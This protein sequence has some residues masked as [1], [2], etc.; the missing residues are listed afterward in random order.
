[1]ASARMSYAVLLV[2]AVSV[3]AFLAAP[4]GSP[5]R[6]TAWVVPC[7]LATCLLTARLVAGPPAVRGPLRVLLTGSLLYTAASV[8]WSVGPVSFGLPLPFPSPLDAAFITSYAVFAAFLLL[9]LRRGPH[10]TGVESRVAVIDALIPTASLSAVLWVAVVEPNLSSGIGAV[11]TAVAIVYPACGLV[12]FALAIRLAVAGRVV[13][14]VPGLLL[15]AW[16][17]CELAGLLGY[18]FQ[19]ANGTFSYDGLLMPLWT[20]SHAA[21]GALAVHPG[22]PALLSSRSEADAPR[23]ETPG[24]R[25]RQPVHFLAALVPLALAAWQQEHVVALLA[26]TAATFALVTYRASLVAGDLGVQRRLTEELGQAVRDVSAHRDRLARL[27]AVVESTDDA[28]ILCTPDGVI[29]GWNAGAERLY[30]YTEAEALGARVTMLRPPE[31]VGVVRSTIAQLGQG[32]AVRMER[33]DVRKDGSLVPTSVTV[34]NIYDDA[35]TITAGVAIARDMTE[36]IRA[37]EQARDAARLLEAQA[38]QLS[39]LAFHDPLTGLGNRALFRQELDE[40]IQEATGPRAPFALVVLDLDD[41]KVVNDSLGHAT[42]DALLVAAADRLRGVVGDQGT[43]ARLGGDEFAVVLP[44]TDEAA[45]VR[46][47]ELILAQCYREFHVLGHSLRTTASIGVAVGTPGADAADL[48]RNADLAMYAAKAA[49]KGKLSV[50]QHEMLAEAQQRLDLENH[51]R[52][53]VHREELHLEYQPIVDAATGE[54][55]SVEAL[56]RWQHPTWGRVSPATFIPV[57]ET[58]GTIVSLGTWVLR[59]ACRDARELASRAGRPV[60]VAVNVSVRQLHDPDFVSVV[61]SALDESGL[62]A[63]LLTLEVTESLLMDED[64]CSTGVLSRLHEMGVHLSIDDFGTGHSSLARLR[65]LPVRELKIDRAFVQEI[66]AEGESGPIVTAIVAMARALGLSVVA[67]GVETSVQLQ[68]LR[69]LGCDAVQGFLLARPVPLDDLRLGPA[70]A[71][72]AAPVTVEDHLIELIEKLRAQ[73]PS[74]ATM[75][76]PV[77]TL[78]REALQALVSAT[79]LDTMYLTRVD[80]TAGLQ[81]VLLTHAAGEDLVP[82]GLVVD[83][84]D[85]LCKRASDAG[86]AYTTDVPGCFPDS[87]AARELGLMTYVSVP[88]RR[89]DGELVGTLCG[90]SAV[91]RDLSP[92]LRTLIEIFALVIGRQLTDGPRQDVRN[93]RQ[94]AA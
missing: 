64:G 61:G 28:V 42:G 24:D 43:V 33:V 85:T 29:T 36:R 58:S 41:F 55:R 53:A 16:I 14:G 56:L 3:A 90:A 51:L 91:A 44:R 83:W 12:L 22:L 50:Y 9:V 6:V 11:P 65:T 63:A 78:V 17:G 8:L 59:R 35:G 48:L 47:A 80:L 75:P 7:V 45:A 93:P 92:D 89:A 67:E 86:P 68:A 49:G 21:L 20:V 23:D 87:R 60:R 94:D 81:Q 70:P 27:A 54:L 69:R 76:E 74:V 79:G 2:G 5:W 62:D 66:A 40:T 26:T 77:V 31:T 4:A 34:S 19:S 72:A 15:L 82:E 32:Q 71:L 52:N 10:G 25:V 73:V 39:E 84:D 57:A 37:E 18:G 13:R 46:V 30:G 38:G 1:M 88:I